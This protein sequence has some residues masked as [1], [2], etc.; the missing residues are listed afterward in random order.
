MVSAGR[1]RVQAIR[2]VDASVRRGVGLVRDGVEGG[3]RRTHSRGAGSRAWLA[4]T[5]EFV[6]RSDLVRGNTGCRLVG[7]LV[8]A[9]H[10]LG[11][12]ANRFGD[13]GTWGHVGRMAAGESMAN[14]I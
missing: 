4:R 8:S 6:G 1:R 11:R 2:N 5:G 10:D 14:A 7:R 3:D 13:C 12:F 9:L